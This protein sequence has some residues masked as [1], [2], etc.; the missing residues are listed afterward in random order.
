MRM[1]Q[2]ATLSL[3]TTLP[4]G[5]ASLITL[6]LVG[7]I[8]GSHLCDGMNTK[9]YKSQ[10]PLTQKCQSITLIGDVQGP[11]TKIIV[12]KADVNMQLAH[13]ISIIFLKGTGTC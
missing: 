10:S 5:D 11:V 8:F 12:G 4:I 3:K 7:N 6:P 1:T 2:T 9:L 13:I